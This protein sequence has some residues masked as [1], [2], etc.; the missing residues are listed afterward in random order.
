MGEKTRKTQE[1]LRFSGCIFFVRTTWWRRGESLS[2][3]GS[4]RGGSDC[5]RQSFTTAP[6]DSLHFNEKKNKHHE[7]ACFSFGYVGQKRCNAPFRTILLS[8]LF[9]PLIR[10]RLRFFHRFHKS[11]IISNRFERACQTGIFSQ[12]VIQKRSI[13]HIV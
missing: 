4:V 12:C 10:K 9:K 7:D 5:H 13:L 2:P 1:N 8:P 6:F 3:A 11:R